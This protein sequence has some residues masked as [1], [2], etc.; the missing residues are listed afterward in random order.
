M[1]ATVAVRLFL[2]LALLPP[3]AYALQLAPT[4]RRTYSP[5]KSQ[6][7]ACTPVM[8][9]LL[10]TLAPLLAFPPMFFAI[11]KISE[12][13]SDK[14]GEE[15]FLDLPEETAEQQKNKEEPAPLTSFLPEVKLPG[16]LAELKLPDGLPGLPKEMP[17]LPSELPELK[18]PSK[19]P[20][21][22]NPFEKSFAPDFF[23]EQQPTYT[24]ESSDEVKGED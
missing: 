16:P 8:E 10:S 9:D 1:A 14:L 5:T 11:Q 24:R 20:S 22:P 7:R 15:G 17:S 12:I 18:L 6:P 4:A 19:L 23:A 3:S 13:G 2:C 21:L